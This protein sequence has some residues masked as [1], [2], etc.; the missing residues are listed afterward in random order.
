MSRAFV[1]DDADNERVMVPQRALLPDGTP[2]LVTPRGLAL[3]QRERETL[4]DELLQVQGDADETPERARQ[5]T[6]VRERIDD[7]EA[8]LASARLVQVPPDATGEVAF[9]A[10]VTTRSDGGEELCFRIV[11][12]DEADPLEGLV[13]FVAPTAAA[14]LG[15]KVGERVTVDAGRGREDL[16]IVA[17]AYPD[18]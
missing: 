17:V 4:E 10:D 2:N 15:R 12:V 1:K 8:R 13:A 3:L 14:V 16:E 7:L 18:D 6:V 5:L 11:G 9:G